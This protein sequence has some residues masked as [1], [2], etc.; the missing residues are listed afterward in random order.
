[1]NYPT[2]IANLTKSSMKKHTALLLIKNP[3]IAASLAFSLLLTCVAESQ[4]INCV[5]GSNANWNNT[6]SWSTGAV[7]AQN[8]E[9]AIINGGASAVVDSPFEAPIQVQVGNGITSAPDGA[10]TINAD[11]RVKDLWVAVAALTSGRVEQ[12]AG[13]VFLQELCLASNGENP[14]EATYDVF[15]GSI[16]AEVLKLGVMGPATLSLEGNGE[17]VSI[18]TKLL[19]GSQ[20]AIR[21]VGSKIGFP[22]LNA[23]GEVTIE[24]G[25]TLT[26]VAVG[27]TVQPGKFTIIQASKPLAGSFEV[28]LVGFEAGKAR[29][30]ENEPGVLLEVK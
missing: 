13:V 8:N 21:V 19:A 28:E 17:V 23:R 29:L 14:G 2:C 26:V 15:G 16:D 5:R 1:M 9:N 25:A 20:A 10:L 11:F 6:E 24:P 12:N 3:I 27:P 4:I 18:P 22:S 30:L 7:P